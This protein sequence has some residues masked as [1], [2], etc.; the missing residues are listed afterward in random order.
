M[1]KIHHGL[2]AIAILG[3]PASIILAHQ[4]L[5]ESLPQESS[6][7]FDIAVV[8]E[9]AYSRCAEAQQLTKSSQCNDLIRS[10]D[11]CAA[12]KN[13]CDPRSVYEVF[14]KLNL[15]PIPQERRHP[16]HSL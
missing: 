13:D 16:T 11:E 14:L 8:V 2:I 5:I 15:S 1:R 7:S 3:G 10:F 4:K 6:G 9:Q 12:R